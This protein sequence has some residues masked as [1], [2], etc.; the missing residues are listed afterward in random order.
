M[1]WRQ[2]RTAPARQGGE[3]L[4]DTEFT[5]TGSMTETG[6][7][8]YIVLME[9]LKESILSGQ[10]RPGEK[11][12]SENQLSREYGL[13]R[14]TVRK[15]LAIL[16]NE[17][18]VTAEHG[19]GTFCSERMRH[20]KN[21]RNIAV[22]TTYLS[23]YIFPRLIQGMDQVL[24]EAGYSIML[25]NTGN[26]R[27]K[28]AQCLEDILTKDVDGLIVEPS[29]SQIL[30]RNM[31]LYERLDAY[32]IPYVFI[33]GRYPQMRDKPCVL[34]DDEK[35]G[36]LAA[37]HLVKLGHRRIAGIFKADDSQGAERHKGY[38]KALQEAQIPY[39]PDLVIWFHTEDRKVKPAL[40]VKRMVEQ[41]WDFTGVVCYND[42]IALEVYRAL[43]EMGMRVPEDISLTGYDDSF[44]ASSG[45][46]KMTT[47][48]HPHER[49]GAM[50]ARMLLDRIRGVHPEKEAILRLLEP[51][52]VI[53]ESCRGLSVG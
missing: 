43:T 22:I 21:S 2:N 1:A 20:R 36:Y 50:A 5:I 48:A 7:T 11:L 46:L 3:R 25:K 34:M 42:Q 37:S 16:E 17:G 41:K 51:E 38:V 30:C 12:P 35:G 26:S 13:S 19:R 8:K 32:E 4:L 6:K 53:R 33:Q 15:A 23:D 24:T 27:Q 29:K 49:L 47:V 9:R 39:D 45:P 40:V 28:E 44:I 18:Y 52:L 31:A 14:H 10:I